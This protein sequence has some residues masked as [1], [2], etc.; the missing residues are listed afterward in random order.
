[1]DFISKLFN[2]IEE[3]K[4]YDYVWIFCST[5]GNQLLPKHVFTNYFENKVFSK[6]IF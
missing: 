2:K 3:N 1:M 5:F 4:K 6:N